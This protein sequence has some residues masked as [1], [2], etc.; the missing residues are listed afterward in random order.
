MGISLSTPLDDSGH[1]T[2]M[3]ISTDT[4][5]CLFIVTVR[6]INY[7]QSRTTWDDDTITT[8]FLMIDKSV[9]FLSHIEPN[10]GS[11]ITGN[12]QINTIAES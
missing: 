2:N 1:N 7:P 9:A 8:I 12:I 3:Q 5:L 10:G 4:L 6:G 11:H